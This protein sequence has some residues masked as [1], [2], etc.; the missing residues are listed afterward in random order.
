MF[1]GAVA[2][3]GQG[4]LGRRV[5]GWDAHEAPTLQREMIGR[6]VIYHIQALDTDRARAVHQTFGHRLK[7]HICRCASMNPALYCRLVLQ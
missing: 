1:E 3:S 2:V 7:T 6:V 4:E 5:K